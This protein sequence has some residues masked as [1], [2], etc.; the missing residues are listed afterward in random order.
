[1][2]DSIAVKEH[3]SLRY[4]IVVFFDRLRKACEVLR[5][6]RLI[7]EQNVGTAQADVE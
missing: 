6:P 1:M 3:C 4:K 7:S 2:F 5:P